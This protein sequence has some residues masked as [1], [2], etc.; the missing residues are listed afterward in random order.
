MAALAIAP[1]H[2]WDTLG[3]MSFVHT[4]NESGLFSEKAL[5][6]LTRF[7]MVTVEKG[8]GFNAPCPPGKSAPCAEDK[9]IAQL[10]AVKKRNSSVAT[11]FYMNSV[12]SWYFYHMNT[13]MHAHRAWQLN[14]SKTGRPVLAPGDKHFNPPK[15]GMLVFAH[16]VPAMQTFWIDTCLNA[17]RTG[18][19]DGCFSDSAPARAELL[20]LLLPPLPCAAAH[21]AHLA[22][23]A[24]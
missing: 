5:D 9:I 22:R 2:S 11:I 13:V 12:L 21:F 17:T 19:V 18:L 20:D 3:T 10:A 7:P 23:L 8:Q 15:D 1:K 16:N 6:T 14:D 24:T 4:C